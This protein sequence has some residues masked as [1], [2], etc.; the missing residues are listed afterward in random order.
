VPADANQAGE[1][2]QRLA[3]VFRRGREQFSKVDSGTAISNLTPEEKTIPYSH[4]PVLKPREYRANMTPRMAEALT[5]MRWTDPNE[6]NLFQYADVVERNLMIDWRGHSSEQGGVSGNK[7][8]GCDSIVL[9]QKRDR[10][11]VS[12]AFIYKATSRQGA[13]ALVESFHSQHAVRVWRS[14]SH[15]PTI[16]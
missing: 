7:L 4:G 2:K 13:M 14:N 3:L 12:Q 15:D 1:G 16:Q 8:F 6:T 5:M 10:H 11:E 9:S